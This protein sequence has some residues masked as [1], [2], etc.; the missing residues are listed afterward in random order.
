MSSDKIQIETR[1][2]LPDLG[3]GHDLR[4]ILSSA[5]KSHTALQPAGESLLQAFWP[6]AH[7]NLDRVAVYRD[8][9]EEE[10]EL[11]LKECSC[12]TLEEAYYI[13]K[14]GI[15]FASK[16][17]LLSESVQERM[18]YSLFGADET[19]HFSWISRYVSTEAAADFIHNPFIE[20]LDDL[21]RD[22]DKITLTYVIQVILEGWGISHYRALSKDC[23]DA[24]LVEV[25]DH[26][27]KDEAR[28]HSS[29][30][31]LFNER[32]LSHDQIESLVEVLSR[33]FLMV[34]V[35]PQSIVS[36]VERVRG[37]LSRAQKIKIFQEM[38]CEQETAG[39]LQTLKSLIRSAGYAEPIFDALDRAG[40]FKPFSAAECAAVSV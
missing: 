11:I 31:V 4:R 7:F 29:G 16:M 23:N 39:K 19:V 27:I 24:G 15:Y 25:F 2:D 33:L 13:E 17:C 26:I 30:L 21:L 3:S 1:L 38:E 6:A 37:H 35:G 5:L 18:L 36:K 12:D 8:A 32:R 9:P 20:L 34:R 22:Q 10:R 14:C 28:H 40:A